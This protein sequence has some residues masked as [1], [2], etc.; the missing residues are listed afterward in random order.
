MGPAL[1]LTDRYV[2]LGLLD[3]QDIPHLQIP[4]PHHNMKQHYQRYV[5]PL[6]HGRVSLRQSAAPCSS[7]SMGCAYPLSSPS[8]SSP[9]SASHARP[10]KTAVEG[11]RSLKKGR[12]SAASTPRHVASTHVI[13]CTH[14]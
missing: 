14:K 9:L 8:S 1:W 7:P 13:T 10:E 6:N 2:H 12:P 4:E 11:L 3:G 5:V